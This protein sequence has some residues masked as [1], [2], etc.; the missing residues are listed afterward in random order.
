MLSDDELRQALWYVPPEGPQPEG[1]GRARNQESSMERPL[2]NG[3]HSPFRLQQVPEV[4]A[5]SDDEL[6][7]ALWYVPPGRAQPNVAK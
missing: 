5:L 3:V 2:P 1:P 7:E 6:R 4:P